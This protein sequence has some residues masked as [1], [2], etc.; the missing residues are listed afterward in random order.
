MIALFI[1]PLPLPVIMNNTFFLVATLIMSATGGYAIERAARVNFQQSL[2]IEE[3]R[4]K[5][6][7]LLLNILPREVT[8]VLKSGP[9]TVAERYDKV[10]ILFADIVGFTPL[11]ALMRADEVVTMLNQVFSHFDS[12][13]EKYGAEKIRTIGDNYMVAAG[14]PRPCEDHAQTL[15]AMALDM[16]AYAASVEV[17][18]GRLALRIGINSGPVIAGVIGRRKFQY[19]VWGDA[20][21]AASR[22]ESHGIPAGTQITAATYDL[23][24]GSFVCEP[25]GLIEVKGMGEMETWFL[26]GRR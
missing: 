16:H 24:R 21:N 4:R 1:S 22:M 11:S 19:D 2:V 14:V 17:R 25:R 12:L 7:A 6:E 13:V 20:V 9:A 26:T 15:A 8:L 5:S 3:E 23:V 18:G 10:S